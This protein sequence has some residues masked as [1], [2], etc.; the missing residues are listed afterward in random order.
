MPK[1][2]KFELSAYYRE[3]WT[4]EQCVRLQQAGNA[5]VDD[6]LFY[7][8]DILTA[9]VS[10]KPCY[11]DWVLLNSK[12]DEFLVE[13]YIGQTEPTYGVVIAI[14]RDALAPV[15]SHEGRRTWAI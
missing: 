14:E 10:L 15:R 7:P 1:T 4:P 12:G 5:W 3:G 8:G 11:G 13:R 2:K 6:G 9:A